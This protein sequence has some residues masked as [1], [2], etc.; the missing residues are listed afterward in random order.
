MRPWTGDWASGQRCTR[1]CGC[2]PRLLVSCALTRTA[3]CFGERGRSQQRQHSQLGS[4]RVKLRSE[5]GRNSIRR[6]SLGMFTVQ[7]VQGGGVGPIQ[8]AGGVWPQPRKRCQL[9]RLASGTLP[10]IFYMYCRCNSA[11]SHLPSQPGLLPPCREQAA[12]SKCNAPRLSATNARGCRFLS[13][14]LTSPALKGTSAETHTPQ[15]THQIGQARRRLPAA[16][17]A[18]SL[19]QVSA[20]GAS[21]TLYS[22]R[23]PQIQYRVLY[24]V[25]GAPWRRR[26]HHPAPWGFVSPRTAQMSSTGCAAS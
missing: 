15:H 19:V 21:N 23:E 17:A 5:R 14:Q 13:L 25:G 3:P 4:T 12:E 2:G 24:F 10:F 26:G 9:M 1:A 16:C 18:S 7:A 8:A 11:R 20:A 22:A 6:A